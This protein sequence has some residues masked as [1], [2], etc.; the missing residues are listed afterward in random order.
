M[1]RVFVAC[2]ARPLR[3]WCLILVLPA[4]I[5]AQAGAGAVNVRVEPALQTVSVLDT[6][7]VTFSADIL[8]PLLGFGFELTFDDQLF[9]LNSTRIGPDFLAAVNADDN[10]MSALA[11]PDPVSGDDILLGT[12]SFTMLD[13]GQGVFGISVADGDP[14]HG[15]AG[16][17]IGAMADFDVA[18]GE[19]R[20]ATELGGLGGGG[21]VTPEPTT[22]SLLGLGALVVARRN[23]R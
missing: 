10:L 11:F 13:A 22:L 15:F 5:P 21:P 9:E 12:A 2:A 16:V 20:A 14:T 7:D 8:E 6:F 17:S 3:V 1:E 4:L 23:R 18:L 19:V